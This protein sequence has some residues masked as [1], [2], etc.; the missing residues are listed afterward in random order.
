MKR[1]PFLCKQS[2][3]R[4]LEVVILAGSLAWET[5]RVWRKDPDR[6]DDVPPM[7][8][9]PNE[10]ADLSNLTIIRPDTLYVRVLRTGDISEEDLLKIAV[11]LAHAGVQM[12]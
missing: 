10:L 12:A 6:E 2:P 3:D 5:S 11:K 7:V 4:T 8:L 9:G 1:A